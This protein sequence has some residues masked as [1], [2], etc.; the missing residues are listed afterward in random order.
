M[1]QVTAVW[2]AMDTRRRFI[3]LAAT[4]IVFAAILLLS[5]MASKP[6]YSLLYAGLEGKSSGEVVS[7]LEQRGVPY[8]IRGDSIYVD[9]TQRDELR[10]TLASE[11]LPAMGGA[12]YEL[13]DSMSGFG[14]TSQMF[15]AA[16]WRAKEGE[17]AR[18]I[19]ANPGIRSARVH[20]AHG[21]DNAF[22]RSIEPT[23]SV[24]ITAVSG[25]IS[26]QQARALKHLV[27]SAVTGMK[28][29]DVSVIDAN[30]GLISTGDDDNILQ[31]GE[32]RAAE[33]KKNVERLLEARVG[34]GNAVVEISLR[35]ALESES[36]TERVIDPASRIAISTDAQEQS[37]SSQS[38]DPANVTVASNL[39][40]GNANA[41]GQSQSNSSQTRERTNFDVSETRREVLR[42]PGSVTRLTVAVLVNGL[43]TTGADG[44]VTWAP[45]PQAELDQLQALVSSAVGFD[46]ARGDVI[47]LQSM[48]FEPTL[49]EGIE[50]MSGGF[51][52]GQNLDVMQLIQL[53]VLAVV[54]LI[55]GLFVMKPILT[56]RQQVAQLPPAAG[57]P[58]ALTGEI[59][60]GDLPDDMPLV[61]GLGGGDE[62]GGFDMPF[63]MGNAFDDAEN[64]A[65]PVD[66]LKRLI[67]ERRDETV[68]I[69]R[70]WMDEKEERA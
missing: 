41:G 23:A 53:G 44:T 22:R 15:D 48:Q 3:V 59:A 69:L 11:G 18:T 65:D 46:E 31:N 60:D 54:A 61:S 57:D 42:K 35:T 55:L 50:A 24:F 70:S 56:Q 6:S 20:I 5:N 2:Q 66:R 68:E 38:T 33:L 7:A 4:G 37:D 17:L 16:Y 34:R 25:S 47:T 21:S 28:P 26:Q 40:T 62:L 14:T 43:P 51:M 27:A 10:M 45:R 64:D 1:E 52:G 9:A 63:A 30:G 13:L 36:I 49:I 39:P 32:D 58:N 29:E 8:E 19:V 12:G 67:E